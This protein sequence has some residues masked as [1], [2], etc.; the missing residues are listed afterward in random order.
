MTNPIAFVD[1]TELGAR[2]D[3]IERIQRM[4]LKFAAETHMAS[5]AVLDQLVATVQAH[6]DKVNSFV[7]EHHDLRG[8][9]ADAKAKLADALTQF[10]SAVSSA[11]VDDPVV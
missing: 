9:L 10:N 4:H 3:N 11:G 5:K 2:L 6:G 7:T 1:A 8:Q